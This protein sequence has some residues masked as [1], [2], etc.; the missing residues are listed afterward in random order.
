G[1][2]EADFYIKCMAWLALIASVFNLNFG[3]QIYKNTTKFRTLLAIVTAP[4][5]NHITYQ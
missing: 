4:S 2:Q 3:D 1:K 5:N